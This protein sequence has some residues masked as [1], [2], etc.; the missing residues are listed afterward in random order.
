MK[1]HTIVSLGERR[2]LT[3]HAYKTK[4]KAE[5]ALQAFLDSRS[6]FMKFVDIVGQHRFVVQEL[7]IV[8]EHPFS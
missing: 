4:A 8:D 6:L 5:E 7:D 1:V 3:P 2:L